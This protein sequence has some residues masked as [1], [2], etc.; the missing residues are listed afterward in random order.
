[1]ASKSIRRCRYQDLISIGDKKSGFKKHEVSTE[2]ARVLENF[3]NE[4]LTLITSEAEQWYLHKSPMLASR[5]IGGIAAGGGI[6]KVSVLP[7]VNVGLPEVPRALFQAY[8]I[9]LVV[10]YNRVVELRRR[11]QD[12]NGN[13]MPNFDK[14][15]RCSNE[16]TGALRMLCPPDFGVI[17]MTS[18]SGNGDHFE[19]Y[20]LKRK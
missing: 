16:V 6:W 4:N 11:F 20:M 19:V 18:N 13:P 3:L 7:D 2:H 14:N 5:L 1:M 10:P 15:G 17:D 9:T 8:Q 12:F